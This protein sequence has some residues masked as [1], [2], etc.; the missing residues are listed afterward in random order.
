MKMLYTEVS[1]RL[2]LL[3]KCGNSSYNPLK[4]RYEHVQF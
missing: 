4:E 1:P 2:S 3:K